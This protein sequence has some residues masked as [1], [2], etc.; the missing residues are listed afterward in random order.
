MRNTEIRKGNC[1]GKTEGKDLGVAVMEGNGIVKSSG[2]RE[3]MRRNEAKGNYDIR[4][5]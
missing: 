1:E 2:R 5:A 4:W 3:I